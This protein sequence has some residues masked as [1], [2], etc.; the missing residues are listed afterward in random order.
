ML[1]TEV[2]DRYSIFLL[3]LLFLSFSCEF[4]QRTLVR[5]F[6]ETDRCAPFAPPPPPPFLPHENIS[7]GKKLF[8]ERIDRGDKEIGETTLRDSAGGGG[9]K[10][11]RFENAIIFV[12]PV[13][14]PVAE[15]KT[16]PNRR[17]ERATPAQSPVVPRWPFCQM[18]R[19]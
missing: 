18:R 17:E 7:T 1:R 3:S 19:L 12:S 16:A 6:I 11:R 13:P 5:D 8:L 2:T 15:R 10:R 4:Y 14:P 9:E